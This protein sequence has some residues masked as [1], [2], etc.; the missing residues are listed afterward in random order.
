METSET[1][2][3]P[4][5]RIRPNV[6]EETVIDLLSKIYGLTVIDIEE[7]NAYDDRNYHVHCKE[8]HVN[9][10]ISVISEHGY[11]IK[12]INSLDSRNT[13]IIDAQTEM[14]L[15]LKGHVDCPIPVKNLKGTYYT[16]F[17]K[18]CTN[19]NDDGD[20]YGGH[21]IRLFVYRPGQLLKSVSSSKELLFKVGHLAA[22]LD[23]RLSKFYHPAFEHHRTMWML[24]STS[25][26][27]YFVFAVHDEKR[28]RL[29]CEIIDTFEKDVMKYVPILEQGV[30]HGDLNEQNILVNEEGTDIVGIIDFGD[31]QKTCL[32][33]ELAIAVCYMLLERNDI[34]EGKHVIEGYQSLRKLTD[35]EK[36]ILKVTVC[37][38]ICQSLV[39]GAYSHLN[40]P[41]N[42]YVLTTQKNGWPLLQ[43]LW[44]IS[45]DD[46]SKIWDLYDQ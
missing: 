39:M 35:L 11:V 45:D 42:E 32:I 7:L 20:D 15:F 44:P 23:T 12:I 13:D 6:N 40:D 37:A 41:K 33:F 25:K 38:R 17:E 2:L 14:L 24:T 29:A 43:E 5:Q 18:T 9:P 34:N 19:D 8:Y 26:L 27:H 22:D 36:K 30:I 31:S 28:K 3:S 21:A 1:L 16:V 10:Y 4:G 46:I